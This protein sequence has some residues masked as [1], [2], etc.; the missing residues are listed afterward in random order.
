MGFFSLGSMD[1]ILPL[2]EYPEWPAEPLSAA[3]S[4]DEKAGEAQEG[5]EQPS[6]PPRH[7]G[8]KSGDSDG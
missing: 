8:V 7:F 2:R 1:D 6:E 5:S 3:T 4:G